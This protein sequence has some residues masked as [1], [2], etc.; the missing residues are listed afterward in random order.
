MLQSKQQ[1]GRLDRRVTFVKPIYETGDSNEDKIVGWEE[2][3]SAPTVSARKEDLQGYE[4]MIGDRLTYVQPAKWTIRHRA[5]LN[6]RMRLVYKT[7]VY[8]IHSITEPGEG[9]RR[10]LEVNTKLLDNEYFT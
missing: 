1:I 5:D 9:R 6:E 7:R 2:I 3:D 10:Y 4:A 8:A